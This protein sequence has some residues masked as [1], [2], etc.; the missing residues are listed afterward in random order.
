MLAWRDRDPEFARALDQ[1]PLESVE[2]KWNL[3]QKIAAGFGNNPPDWRAAT[4]S[5]ERTFPAEFSRPETQVALQANVVQNNLTIT[6]SAEEYRRS[7]AQAEESRAKVRELFQQYRPGALGN[8]NTGYS[9][10]AK[11][12]MQPSVLN[13]AT[14][15]VA[16]TTETDVSGRVTAESIKVTEWEVK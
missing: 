8:G 16:D 3:I 7:E 14:M 11:S 15:R 6:I 9:N 12:N 13:R 4:W 5:L 2:K 1:A 10:I